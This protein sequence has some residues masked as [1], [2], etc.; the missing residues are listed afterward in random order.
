M[1]EL[2]RAAES[3][4]RTRQALGFKMEHERWLL[5]DFTAAMDRAGIE[6]VTVEAALAWATRP[7]G[8]DPAWWGARLAVVRIFARWLVAF[9]PRTEVPP[10]SLLAVRSRRAE[11]YPY[12]DD[13]V[14]A[15]MHAARG[16]SSALRSATYQTLIGSLAVTGMRV[17][18]AIALNREDVDWTEAV[19]VVRKAKYDHSR[20]VVL[21]PSTAEAL[22]AYAVVRDRHCPRPACPGFFVSLAGTRLIYANVAHTF[23]QLVAEIGLQ[24]RSDRCRPRI[25][26]LR[27]RFALTTLVGWYGDGDD[28]EARLPQLSTYLGHVEPANTY[29]YLRAAPELLALAAERLERAQGQSR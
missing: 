20:E 16:I 8:A 4:V 22:R 26:D 21:H 7:V 29:W 3:Y 2:R 15:L 12:T 10:A 27:H 6:I 9:E 23:H 1:T 24:P 14:V 19:I 25:H 11:P 5:A 18:E 13:D 17:G 28:V